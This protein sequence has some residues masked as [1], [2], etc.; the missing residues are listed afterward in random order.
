MTLMAR[1]A[2]TARC[3]RALISAGLFVVVA[4]A[5]LTAPAGAVLDC[6]GVMGSLRW[7]DLCSASG[8]TVDA[9][10]LRGAMA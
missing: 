2:R 4:A 7:M 6:V 10:L 3:A 5:P 9:N 8:A 1:T